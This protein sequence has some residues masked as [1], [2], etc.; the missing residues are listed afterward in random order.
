[1]EDEFKSVESRIFQSEYGRYFDGLQSAIYNLL[2][3]VSETEMNR[4]LEVEKSV[5]AEY[6]NLELEDINI[7]FNQYRQG[8]QGQYH[9]C[10]EIFSKSETFLKLQKFINNPEK[11]QDAA[12]DIISLIKEN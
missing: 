8:A 9:E 4:I 2:N 6:A 3:T 11:V 1:M 7:L 12:K 10:R 5:I